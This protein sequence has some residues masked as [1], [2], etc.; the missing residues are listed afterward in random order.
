MLYIQKSVL[1]NAGNCSDRGRKIQ[2]F[3]GG[4]Y[5]QTPPTH[6][7]L[8]A[9]LHQHFCYQQTIY[10][11]STLGIVWSLFVDGLP[12]DEFLKNALAQMK[13]QQANMLVF[14][15]ENL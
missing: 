4:E 5:L 14:L 9:I 10:H 6:T 7:L 1:E 12:T 11:F 15:A 8:N 3:S 2:R 13:P